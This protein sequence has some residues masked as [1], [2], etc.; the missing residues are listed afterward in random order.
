M[1]NCSTSSAGEDLA[2][3]QEDNPET[4]DLSRQTAVEQTSLLYQILAAPPGARFTASG[5]WKQ[6]V[7]A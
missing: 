6:M 5:D 2:L 7:A 3:Y 4:C 1:L